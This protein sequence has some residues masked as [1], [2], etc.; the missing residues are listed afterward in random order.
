MIFVE[1]YEYLPVMTEAVG[2]HIVIHNQT[3][4]PFPDQQAIS[5]TTGNV[6]NIG[7]EKV[8]ERIVVPYSY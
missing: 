3:T 7:I 1:E 2:A 6:V 4:M 5:V 8:T